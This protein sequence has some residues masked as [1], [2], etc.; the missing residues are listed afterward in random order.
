M[1]ALLGLS[2]WCSLKHILNGYVLSVFILDHARFALTPLLS[3]RTLAGMMNPVNSL[4]GNVWRLKVAKSSTE[5]IA[6]RKTPTATISE[7]PVTFAMLPSDLWPLTQSDNVS[8]MWELIKHTRT[9]WKATE[10]IPSVKNQWRNCDVVSYHKVVHW[11]S[12]YLGPRW[13]LKRQETAWST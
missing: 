10:L 7:L 12:E 4:K 5:F 8:D 6:W 1:L 9:R 2:F 13:G 3:L 11:N